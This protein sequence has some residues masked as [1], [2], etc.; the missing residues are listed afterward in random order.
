MDLEKDMEYSIPVRSL[1][2]IEAVQAA[3]QLNPEV[4]LLSVENGSIDFETSMV[5]D[6]ASNTLKFIGVGE[7]IEEGEIL[8]TL[9][10]KTRQSGNTKDLIRLSK[11]ELNLR[12]CSQVVRPLTVN[13]ISKSSNDLA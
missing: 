12:F 5:F 3:I 6:E 8:F 4:E 11:E 7:L 2:T 10:L 13:F 1:N 9:H